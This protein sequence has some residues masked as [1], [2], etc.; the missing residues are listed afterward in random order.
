MYDRENVRERDRERGGGVG[1]AK[2]DLKSDT[3][4]ALK[5]PAYVQDS[6][7]AHG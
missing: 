7:K 5:M 4:Y 2:H 6:C 1:Q 3:C